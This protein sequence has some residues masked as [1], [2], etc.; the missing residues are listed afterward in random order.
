MVWLRIAGPR[1]SQNHQIR[2]CRNDVGR[3][4]R[5]KIAALW[6][7]WNVEVHE[8]RTARGGQLPNVIAGLRQAL[9]EFTGE[10][11]HAAVAP[12]HD[13]FAGPLWQASAPVDCQEILIVVPKAA[14]G[15]E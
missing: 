15:I 14:S 11:R 5:I 2:L 9:S 6:A 10:L 3:D 13:I 4:G 1:G 12:H 7:G 8:R